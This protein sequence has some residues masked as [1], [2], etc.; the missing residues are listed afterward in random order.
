MLPLAS[1]M[2]APPALS[3]TSFCA[4]TFTESAVEMTLTVLSAVQEVSEQTITVC[5]S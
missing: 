4:S 1:R 3:V 5:A 2:V